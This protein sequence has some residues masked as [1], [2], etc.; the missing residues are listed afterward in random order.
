MKTVDHSDGFGGTHNSPYIY[1]YIY[2]YK[3]S[4][5][6]TMLSIGQQFPLILY[7]V[8]GTPAHVLLHEFSI[9]IHALSFLGAINA[10]HKACFIKYKIYFIIYKLR[11][12]LDKLSFIW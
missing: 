8:R 6:Y 3:S 9:K 4:Y 12:I 2:I 5:F 7:A 10:F 11:F 1:I